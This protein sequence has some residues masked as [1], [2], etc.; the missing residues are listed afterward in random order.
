MQDL[1]AF[2][3]EELRRELGNNLLLLHRG[4][5][6]GLPE[7]REDEAAQVPHAT[8]V[9]GEVKQADRITDAV[10]T[11]LLDRVQIQN[12]QKFSVVIHGHSPD[13]QLATAQTHQTIPVIHPLN[14]EGLCGI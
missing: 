2:Q 12:L 4:H 14:E 7:V 11:Q 1:E 5:R 8:Q 6:E 10:H 3:F 9:R 13:L